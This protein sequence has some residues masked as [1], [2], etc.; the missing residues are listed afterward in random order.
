M[1]GGSDMNYLVL[2]RAIKSLV[3]ASVEFYCRGGKPTSKEDFSERF[4][5]CTGVDAVGTGQFSNEES[6]WGFTYEQLTQKIA[7]IEA[8]D[9][10]LSYQG[11]RVLEYPPIGDQLDALWKGGTAA[12][13]MLAKV[14]AVKAK[15]PKPE[16]M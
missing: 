8:E 10:A 9:I 4:A 1:D 13:E 6:L 12:T 5:I 14:Q 7:E 11:K 3:P 15:Y 16:G 2:Y